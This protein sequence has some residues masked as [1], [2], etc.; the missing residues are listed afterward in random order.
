MKRRRAPRE[1]VLAGR[2]VSPARA[3]IGRLMRRL[4]TRFARAAANVGRN[5]GPDNLHQLR[6]SVR[7]LRAV[8]RALEGELN[9]RLTAE[10]QFD[11]KNV[12]R[13]TGRLRDADTRRLLLLPRLRDTLEL[14]VALKRDCATLV[15]Q[16]RVD[17]RRMLKAR[18]RE[19]IWTDRLARIRTLTRNDELVAWLTQSVE[20]V[21]AV[22]LSRQLRDLQRR[23]RRRGAGA[24]R[25]HRLRRRIRDVRYAAEALVPMARRRAAPLVKELQKLQDRLGAAHDLIQARRFLAQEL[26]PLEARQALAASLNRELERQVRRCRKKLRTVAARPPQSWVTW[27]GVEKR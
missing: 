1:S 21:V 10:L 19:T 8:L 18:M 20:D 11:L 3:A 9:P 14:P 25:L 24:A 26:L 17:E 16:A 22:S 12:T 27:I 13:E 2:A 7:R 5:P 23:M 4:A 15:E 6:I